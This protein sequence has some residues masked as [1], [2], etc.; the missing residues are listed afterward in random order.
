MVRC[1]AATLGP[2]S[3]AERPGPVVRINPEELHFND[4]NFIDEVYPTAG[5]PRDKQVHYVT[6]ATGPTAEA[7]FATIDHKHHRIRR[8]AMNKFFS[9]AQIARLE[10]EVKR[11]TDQLCDKIIRLGRDIYPLRCKHFC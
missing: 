9:R 3:D 2:V 1:T 6:F 4:P 7:M 8:G 11:L 10:P 5:R